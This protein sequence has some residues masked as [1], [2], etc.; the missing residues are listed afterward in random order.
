MWAQTQNNKVKYTERYKDIT[1]KYRTVSVTFLKDTAGNRK[2]AADILRARINEMRPPETSAITLNCAIERYLAYQRNHV[3]PSTYN[4]NERVLNAVK[5]YLRPSTPLVRLSAGYVRDNLPMD[6]PTLYNE[7]ITRLKAFLRWCY[8]NDLIDSVEWLSKLKPLPTDA[9]IKLSEK[10]LEK[11]ELAAVL[12]ALVIHKWRL[13]TEFLA[14]TGLRIG[15]FMA[16]KISDVD[17]QTRY[18][19]INKTYMRDIQAVSPFAKT[20]ASTREVYIQAELL[21]VI[22]EIEKYRKG[23]K[24]S[25]L[26]F[27]DENGGYLHYDAYRQYLGDTA[28]RTINRRITPHI[29]R[30]TMT[31]LFAA[32]GVRLP[33]ISRRLGHNDSKITERVY[34]HVTKNLKAGDAEEINDV[35]LF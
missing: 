8:D 27:P 29:L 32:E 21:P 34:F 24:R 22:D 26:F 28:E 16:L 25:A 35:R 9:K 19:H 31:S 15:E 4:R 5:R 10:Y 33:V 7:R 1:G 20:E 13:V 17:K 18:I 14:L 23:C 3:R 11:D 6:V 12:D 2:R 30:H